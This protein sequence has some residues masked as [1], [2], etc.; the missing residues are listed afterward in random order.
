[1]EWQKHVSASI[2]RDED[3]WK[4][5]IRVP[6]DATQIKIPAH[7]VKRLRQGTTSMGLF[8]VTGGV[9]EVHERRGLWGFINPL[10]LDFFTV[11]V[12]RQPQQVVV[13]VAVLHL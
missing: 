5:S 6:N 2:A 12:D 3:S 9:V 11:E 8:L 4:R 10:H 1:M 7:S 13:A